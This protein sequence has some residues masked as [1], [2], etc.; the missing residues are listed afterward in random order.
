MLLAFTLKD[1]GIIQHKNELE[2][3]GQRCP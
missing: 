3:L 1:R 2:L